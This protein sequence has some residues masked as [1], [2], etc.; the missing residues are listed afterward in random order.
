MLLK[1][2]WLSVYELAFLCALAH[3]PGRATGPRLNICMS[4]A[5]EALSTHPDTHIIL[6]LIHVHSPHCWH[7]PP[8]HL[9]TL[10]P[11]SFHLRNRHSPHLSIILPF[12]KQAL[13]PSNAHCPLP[14]RWLLPRTSHPSYPLPH[15]P[16]EIKRQVPH[17]LPIPSPI[18]S[19]K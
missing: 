11:S 18:L 8:C 10:F 1:T 7:R 6:T 5:A 4:L 2:S 3:P 16:C 9:D 17:T 19:V 12:R 15:P 14:P 13:S